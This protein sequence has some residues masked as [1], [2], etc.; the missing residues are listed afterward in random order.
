MCGR[1]ALTISPEMVRAFL[2]FA[3]LPNF[4]PRYNIAPT[5]PVGVVR[6]YETERHFELLRWGFI[7]GWAKDLKK[8][9]LMINARSETVLEKPAFRQ[10]IRRRR[11]LIP[12]DAFY[13][14]QKTEGG[15]KRPFMIRRPDKSVFAFAAI[16]EHWMDAGGS[17][18]E[19]TA[20]LTVSAN[21][22][23][24]PIHHRMPVTVPPD[25]FDIWL[26]NDETHLDD[27]LDLMKPASNDYFEA[28]EVSD[29][30]NKVKH[31]DA[32]IQDPYTGNADA[33]EEPEPS[34][35]SDQLD[36]F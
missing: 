20:I 36:L 26:E 4:P 13:E 5:Q 2:R 27:A 32:S 18:M 31:D 16:W 3:G 28:I 23:L 34:K 11:C 35:L 1:F 19:T 8:L 12:A 6:N 33:V 30:V 25:Q 14:W 17:E 9:P 21:E 10:A 24:R 29:R 7:P 15:A 22:A